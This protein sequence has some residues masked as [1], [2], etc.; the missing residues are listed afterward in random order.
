M[1]RLNRCRKRY[2]LLA[3]L[4]I[5]TLMN[6]ARGEDILVTSDADSG[7]GSLRAALST[8]ETG[9]RVVFDLPGGSVIQLQSAL[10]NVTADISFAN[11]NAGDVTI[12]RNGNGPLTFVG[13]A[14]DPTILIINSGGLP[15]LDADLVGSAN[16][17]VYGNGAITANLLIPGTLSPG[18]SSA[19][20]VIG[21]FSV[22]GD[23]DLS[24]GELQVDLQAPGGVPQ[25][26]LL[27][28]DGTLT[29]SDATLAPRFIGNEFAI[30]QQFVVVDS[31][32]PIVG[33]FLNQGDAFALPNNPFLQAVQ[34]L[35]LGGDDFG[36]VIED[37]GLP[38]VSVVSGCNQ[39]S[40]ANVLDELVDG[41]LAPGSVLDLREGSS[42]EVL[43]AVNQLSGSLYP[44]LIG[45]EI[46]HIQTGLD[47]VRN[48]TVRQAI[49][50]RVG[51]FPWAKGYGISAEVDQDDCLTNGYRQEVGGM[52]LGCG[53]DSGCGIS[54]N[55]FSHLGFGSVRTRGVDQRAEVDSYR[56]GG[57]MA[58]R[59]H[60]LYVLG[61]GGAGLQNYDVRRSLSAFDGS[62]SVESSFDGSSQFGY[63]EVGY[64][65]PCTLYLAMHA[66]R[67]KLDS[68]TE[69][70]DDYFALSNDGGS[71]D[72][73]RG[74]L[75]FAIVKSNVTSFGYATTRLRFGWLHEYLD[76]SETFVSQI[77]AG[78][79]TDIALVDRGVSAGRDWG[80]TRVQ[81]DLGRVAGGYMTLGYE[82]HFNSESAF[83]WLLVGWMY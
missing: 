7:A 67:V 79:G 42:E 75:G 80:F 83:N 15:S 3:L 69:T 73:L 12:D 16:T 18:S 17:T 52:E 63:F 14:V 39:T 68:I 43:L 56:L 62:T 4:G 51:L 36:F 54:G 41:G 46:N 45:A 65:D 49:C 82:G 38:F 47:S 81:V 26:D 13:P 58:Y 34:D 8:A 50:R 5:T 55:V 20:G 31:T 10:P 60:D 37:N 29:V 2:A 11:N 27:E 32:N 23:A 72:S 1:S 28:V 74:I 25:S 66:T 21:T 19:E 30:G 22:T 44:S 64:A 70:G 53:F 35:G 48:M 77:A 9:D 6:S 59:M 78:N 33:S 57:S 71:G 61:A 24:N 40:A 76:E